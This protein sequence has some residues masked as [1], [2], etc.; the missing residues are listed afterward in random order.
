MKLVQAREWAQIYIRSPH[1]LKEEYS[2]E[3]MLID[4]YTAGWR[5]GWDDGELCGYNRGREHNET[6]LEVIRN[7]GI[8]EGIERGRE[9]ERMREYPVH[10][11]DC[12]MERYSAFECPECTCKNGCK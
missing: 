6:D 4:A 10:E 2:L 11:P 8:Q 7:A 9:L 12:D 5:E 3:D 1:A